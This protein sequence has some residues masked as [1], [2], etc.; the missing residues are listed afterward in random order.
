M[1]RFVLSGL[2]GFA[3]LACMAATN[4][5][6]TTEAATPMAA[7]LPQAV[8]TI[9]GVPTEA[10]PAPGQCRIF[11]NNVEVSKQPAAMECEH[12]MW[13]A[14]SWG[15]RVVGVTGTVASVLATYEGRN[16]FTGVPSNALPPR[17]YCRAW[18][19]GLAVEQQPQASD[20]VEARHIAQA[21][22]G[23]VLFMPL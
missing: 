13:L 16:D 8:S 18:I 23:R 22:D 3:A 11:F 1:R 9:A 6:P 7:P 5:I 12:A 17:G 21:Q 20:C 10:L 19:D 15:G 14:R 4:M 2:F